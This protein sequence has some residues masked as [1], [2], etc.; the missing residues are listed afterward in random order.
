MKPS[1]KQVLLTTAIAAT[2]APV[3]S[4]QD[5]PFLRGRY[6]DVTERSQEEFDPRPVRASGF[7]IM[8]SAGVSGEYN[9]NILATST[10]EISDTIIR[11]TP[12][13]EARSTWSV[14]ELAAGAELTHREYVD[15]GDESSTDYNL[16]VNG[17]ID[18]TRDFF[19]RLGA[20][21]GHITEQRY[22]AGSSGA[23]EAAEYD[24]SS[25]FAQALYRSDRIQIEGT[26][27]ASEDKFDQ[28]VQQIRDNSTTYVNA[29][30][31]YAISP[32]IAVF[33]Q[34][35]QT[36]LDYDTGDRDGTRTTIDA[37]VNFELAA[38]IRGE[39]AVGNF[40]DDRDSPAYG[41][42][43]GLNVAGNIK[44]FPT[45]LTT[46]TFVANRGVVD[47]GLATSATSVNTTFGIRVDHELLRN[48]LLFGNLRQETNEF[49]GI[50]IDREDDALALA[51]GGAYKL[52]PNMHLEFELTTR[53]QDSSGLNA[54]PE[55]DVNTISA[56]IRFFP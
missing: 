16:F 13:I 53:S 56:G 30:V 38:P 54:G 37:G 9:D 3:A 40:T 33:V 23:G 6:I 19:F 1:L 51:V 48:L 24:A 27:G 7:D 55:L 46:V 34:G 21:T 35:R 15:N 43:E 2:I 44:W 25:V 4:A 5:N 45:D 17:R 47:P 31:S 14:H 28:L 49:E 50:A 41:D 32:D 11:A 8:A 39:I 36:E 18:V 10:N 12:R 26:I 20:D 22:A 52:N 29:R 42:V